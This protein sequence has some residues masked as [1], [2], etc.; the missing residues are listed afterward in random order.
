MHRLTPFFVIAFAVLLAAGAAAEMRATI[1]KGPKGSRGKQVVLREDGTWEYAA[2]RT[3]AKRLRDKLV[4]GRAWGEE[5]TQAGQFFYPC[6]IAVDGS[7]NVYVADKANHRIQVFSRAGK[8]LRQWKV[9]YHPVGLAFGPDQELYVTT[10]AGMQAP[11]VRVFDTRGTQLRG[12]GTAGK[13]DG[14]FDGLLGGV[15]VDGDGNVYVA[16]TFTHRI[17]KFDAEGTYLAQWGSLGTGEGQFNQPF[18]VAV[19]ADGN[20]YVTDVMNFRVQKFTSAGRFL[21][22]WGGKGTEDGQFWSGPRGLF[23]D[24][25][26]TVWTTATGGGITQIQRFDAKGTFLMGWGHRDGGETFDLDGVEHGLCVLSSGRVYV[27]DTGHHRIRNFRLSH[28]RSSSAPSY[29]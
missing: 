15:A 2:G 26:G 24:A 23:V 17:Q 10:D 8:P 19:D 9:E 11:A 22:A 16:D 4:A 1:I 7:T 6:G 13:G 29:E 12:W 20:V 5:G 14:Q 27:A 28:S 21:A 25:A 18:N 3:A